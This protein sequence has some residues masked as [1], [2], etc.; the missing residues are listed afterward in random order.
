ME[1]AQAIQTGI[2]SK[3]LMQAASRRIKAKATK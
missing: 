2:L 1:E 3:L